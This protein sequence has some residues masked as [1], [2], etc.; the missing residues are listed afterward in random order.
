MLQP[1]AGGGC[2]R[3][4]GPASAVSRQPRARTATPGP[5]RERGA[6]GHPAAAAAADGPRRADLGGPERLEVQPPCV[7]GFGD[8]GFEPRPGGKGCARTSRIPAC[9]PPCVTSVAVGVTCCHLPI[10]PLN[11]APVSFVFLSTLCLSS[12]PGVVE[13]CFYLGLRLASVSLDPVFPSRAALIPIHGLP[14]GAAL[15]PPVFL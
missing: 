7:P 6:Q 9:L 2:P 11:L 8:L 15:R 1:R 3:A 14:V 4:P 12:P 13:P 10:P 5:P